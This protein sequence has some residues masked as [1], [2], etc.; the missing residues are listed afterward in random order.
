MQQVL[1]QIGF[2]P[3]ESRI[4]MQLLQHGEQAASKVANNIGLP[5]STVRGSL[6]KLCERGVVQKIYKRNTQYYCCKNPEALLQD[7]ELQQ[8]NLEQNHEAVTKAL[9]T[10]QGLFQQNSLVPKVR[11][12]EGT[13]QV[14]EAFNLSLYAEPEEILFFTSYEFLKSDTIRKN[15]DD[16]YVPMR[17]GKG[18]PLR[19]L[20]GKTEASCKMI[21]HSPAELRERRFIPQDYKL[22]GNIQI[23]N[24]SVVYFSSSE[25]EMIAVLV[26]SAL[27]AETMR[28]LFE[29]MWA[30]LD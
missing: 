9:P 7:L 23:F 2:N 19:A 15:D 30:N 18:I 26:E 6:D 29:F 28:T 11:F 1:E 21:K 4:Y 22:P 13:E 12:F 10:L 8:Q 17:I 3:H 20:V 14:I 27:M 24:D 5:R 16:F 25:K